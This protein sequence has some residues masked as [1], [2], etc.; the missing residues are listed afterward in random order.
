MIIKRKNKMI[1]VLISSPW[2]H[3]YQRCCPFQNENKNEFSIPPD[4]THHID[5][6]F[7]TH[8]SH[9][10]GHWNGR[11]YPHFSSHCKQSENNNSVFRYNTNEFFRFRFKFYE[12]QK[13]KTLNSLILRLKRT[14]YLG[15]LNK[16]D[17][18]IHSIAFLI[19]LISVSEIT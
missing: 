10:C 11:Q 3:R 15:Y 5:W 19:F 17:D 13:L 18:V 6:N 9:F 16:F 14:F 12:H 4:P 7:E 2:I 1:F 8:D